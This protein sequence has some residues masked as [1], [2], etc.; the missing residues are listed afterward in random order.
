MSDSTSE[1]IDDGGSAFPSM[2]PGCNYCT[3]GMGLRDWFAGQ[4][5]SGFMA[6]VDERVYSW[7]PNGLS[8]EEWRARLKAEDAEDMY[9]MADA[10]LNVREKT[11]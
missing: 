3:T 4:A 7:R 9:R 10:M 2:L 6:Q 5:L 11:T 1:Q 8:I